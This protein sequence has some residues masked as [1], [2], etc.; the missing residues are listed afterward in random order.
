MAE[1]QKSEAKRF[2]SVTSYHRS[3]DYGVTLD[4]L[5]SARKRCPC[6]EHELM[7]PFE[8]ISRPHHGQST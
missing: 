2:T 3:D 5:L 8:E 7:W 1:V 4:A 6:R